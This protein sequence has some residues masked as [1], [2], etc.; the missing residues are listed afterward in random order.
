MNKLYYEST[1]CY[2]QEREPCGYIN[3]DEMQQEPKKRKP[4]PSRAK[5][6]PIRNNPVIQQQPPPQIQYVYAAPPPSPNVLS[7]EVRKPR[8]QKTKLTE[9][10]KNLQKTVQIF[11]W[12]SR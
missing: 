8:R 9:Q 2:Q 7:A 11:S 5:P 12:S 1:Q 4:R 10:E 3:Y 6:Q